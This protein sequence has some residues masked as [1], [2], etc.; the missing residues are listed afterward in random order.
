MK[1]SKN[2]LAALWGVTLLSWALNYNDYVM[3][4]P[5]SAVGALVSVLYV[6]IWTA[7]T[8]YNRRQELI[9]MSLAWGGI[10]LL[11][12]SI[13]FYI[14]TFDLISAAFIPLALLFLTPFYGLTAFAPDMAI[15]GAMIMC[16][17]A[18]VLIGYIV[19]RAS[20]AGRTV[21]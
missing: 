21:A 7:F 20:R 13:A 5:A 11:V 14:A 3:G 8:V 2:V 10:T 9:I 18:W 15:Y 6:V 17:L 12:A 4:D 16:S 1:Q 19:L